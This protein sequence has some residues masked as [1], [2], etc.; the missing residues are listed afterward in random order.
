MKRFKSSLLSDV[1]FIL[2]LVMNFIIV[3]F[4]ARDSDAYLVNII[5]FNI[6][7]LF[8]V[9]AYFTT[10]LTVLVL[11]AVFVFCLGTY[12]LFNTIIAGDVVQTYHYFWLVVTPIYCVLTW[13]M[14]FTQRK[15][16][17][18]N[19]QLQLQQESLAA[20]DAGTRLKNIISYQEDAQVF[21]ALSVR[22]QIPLTLFI[23]QVKYW[24][25]IKRMV[26]HVQL[27][28]IVQE[29]SKLGQNSIRANDVLYMIDPDYPTW[30]LLLLTDRQGAQT[31]IE[32]LKNRV[33][34]WNRNE[35]GEINVRLQLRIGALE[36]E[37]ET[38]L[39]PLDFIA[40]A[41]KQLEYDV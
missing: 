11:N 26:N 39:T 37:M 28:E 9:I 4:I 19:E 6:A 35:E 13:L 40:Q 16:Q 14:I 29:L 12:T 31:V 8:A 22:Y 30:G 34:D 36:Y 17:N 1:A 25:E 32:R 2:F 3:S 41:K 10:L 5:F 27:T 24:N 20:M 7:L 18:E 15:L 23:I 38:I 21:M 33:D